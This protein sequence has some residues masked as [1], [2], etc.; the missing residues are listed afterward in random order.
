MIRH[1]DVSTN[2]DMMFRVRSDRELHK[3]VIYRL[4]CKKLPPSMCAKCDKIKRIIC[5]NARQPRWNL[6]IIIGHR[7]LV[8]SYSADLLGGHGCSRRPADDARVS[9]RETATRSAE[10]SFSFVCDLC[11]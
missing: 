5:E 6:G 1:D 2:S 9:H 11:N 3:G 10:I 4:D 8:P 7:D